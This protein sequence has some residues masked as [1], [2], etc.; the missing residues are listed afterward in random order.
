MFIKNRVGGSFALKLINLT[1]QV[2]LII[3]IKNVCSKQLR[4]NLGCLRTKQPQKI[5]L[6]KMCAIV[7]YFIFFKKKN[8]V[9]FFS[10]KYVRA[11]VHV[12]V[13]GSKCV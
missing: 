10:F 13:C 11:C 3:K 7:F 9:N 8:V 2:K 6:A 12:R 5:F 4:R 1:G